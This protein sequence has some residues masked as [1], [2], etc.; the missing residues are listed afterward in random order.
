MT[1]PNGD[2]VDAAPEVEQAPALP[3][4]SGHPPRS[5][6]PHVYQILDPAT[7]SVTVTQRDIPGADE[8]SAD[9]VADGKA[10]STPDE[11]DTDVNGDGKTEGYEVFTKDELVAECKAR[12]LP[13]TGN[14]PDLVARLQAADDAPA[15][16]A[17]E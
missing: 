17:G 8:E 14:K 15:Q 16:G 2:T 11:A 12:G 13:V 4:Y 10:E 1:E 7:T 6:N 5:H 9:E 3:S